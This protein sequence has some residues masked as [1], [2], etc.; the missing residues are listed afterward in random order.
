VTE[1]AA[2]TRR[3]LAFGSNLCFEQMSRRCPAATV[4]EVVQLEG[5]RFVINRN[6]FAT[7]LAVPGA[8]AWGLVWQLTPACEVA[9]D[10]YEGVETGEYRKLEWQV[11]AAPALVY[12][13]SEE[14]FGPA[15]FGYLERILAAAATLS[16]PCDYLA[17]IG[18]WA[19]VGR[20]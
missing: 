10:A 9:L 16:L 3:Y 19:G 6:G 8:V 11:G 17:E 4:G 2:T 5:R 18:A 15:R 12:L 1:A 13:A 20:G 7:L 14:R